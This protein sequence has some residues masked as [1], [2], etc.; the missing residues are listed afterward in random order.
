ME[1]RVEWW[2]RLTFQSISC[3]MNL[4]N[5]KYSLFRKIYD[6]GTHDNIIREFI[7]FELSLWR[8]K[9]RLWTFAAWH[10]TVQNSRMNVGTIPCSH[11]LDRNSDLQLL[12]PGNQFEEEKKT[13]ALE[14]TQ[15]HAIA[16]NYNLLI[17]KRRSL[18]QLVVCRQVKFNRFIG[19]LFLNNY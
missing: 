10:H 5:Q 17:W 7:I 12:M 18:H 19:L 6:K 16:S 9:I 15:E 14:D 11:E 2:S 4:N 3:P 8:H 1:V 13:S